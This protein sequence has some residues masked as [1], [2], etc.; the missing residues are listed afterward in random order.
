MEYQ[1]SDHWISLEKPSEKIVYIIG[2]RR[3]QNQI[4]ARCLEREIGLR[5]VV[6]ADISQVPSD[7]VDGAQP[8]AVL[9]DCQGTDPQ[10]LLTQLKSYSGNKASGYPLVLFN[11][12]AEL[13]VEE[14][15]VLEGIEGFFYEQDSID[16]FFKGVVAVLNGEMWL[17]RR[18]MTKCI[19]EGRA[20]GNIAKTKSSALSPRQ[21]EILALVA[22]GCSNDE[23]ADK[24]CISTHT[25]KVH[26]YNIYKKIDVPNRLQAALW[27]AK[28]L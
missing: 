1:S 11:A 23:I 26:L 19:R 9:L 24:L 20:Q 13:G 28:N 25:V 7:G 5:C 6:G 27:A 14:R 22:V 2:P 15:C 16:R 10:E 17:S 8:S 4:V 12:R 3:L 18:L 21:M